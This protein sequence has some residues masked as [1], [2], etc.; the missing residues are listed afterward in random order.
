MSRGAPALALAL[1]LALAGPAP[2]AD[3]P[4]LGPASG[5]L[6][7]ESTSI[8]AGIGVSWGSGVLRMGER[9]YSFSLTGLSVADVGVA[10]VTASGEVWGLGDDAS[11]LAGTYYG[12]DIGMAVGG[13]SAGIAMRNEHGVYIK[14]RAAQQGVKLSVATKGTTIELVE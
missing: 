10:R 1:L 8:A 9:E 5:T 2:A 7:I 12:V 13:G 6:T 4:V 11:K 3:E 14:L